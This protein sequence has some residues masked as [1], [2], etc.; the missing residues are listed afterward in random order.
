LI[1]VVFDDGWV[2]L[3]AQRATANG[4]SILEDTRDLYERRGVDRDDLRACRADGPD[5]TSLPNCLKVYL[6]PPTVEGPGRWGMVFVPVRSA[7]GTYLR[8]L[9][10]GIRHHPPGSRAPTVYQLADRRLSSH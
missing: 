8:Y 5:G 7:A 2:S 10:F 6:G 3:D 9:A 1:D 4:R